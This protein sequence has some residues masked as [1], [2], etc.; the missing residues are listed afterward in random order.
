M[1]LQAMFATIENSTNIIV[2]ASAP[3]PKSVE[4]P[5]ITG[6]DWS[7]GQFG[8]RPRN[9]QDRQEEALETAHKIVM[10][11]LIGLQFL[12]LSFSLG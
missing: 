12:P 1:L 10:H 9:P 2:N 11:D 7:F 6:V 4:K 8:P 3:I 5:L